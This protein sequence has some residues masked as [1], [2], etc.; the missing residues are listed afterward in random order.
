MVGRGIEAL[1]SFANER[2][3]GEDPAV[4]Q[5]IARLYTLQKL[6]VWNG[7]RAKESAK[8]G[9]GLSPAAS[10]GKLMVSHVTRQWRETGMAIAEGDGMLAGS[11]GPMDGGVARQL[12]FTPAPSIYGGSDQ[13]QRNIIG[14]RVLGLP[15]DP[16]VSRD[17]PFRDLR[18]GTQSKNN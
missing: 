15:K 5:Q 13:V 9:S 17:V 14:E 4:R 3:R 7:L 11:D 2:K 8:S 16:D 1:V 6:N 12:L 18:V 10:L